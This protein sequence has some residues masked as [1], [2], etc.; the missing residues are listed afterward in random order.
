MD[1]TKW[2][3]IGCGDVTE[4]KS[5]PAFKKVS[6]SSLV[7]VMRRDAVKAKD[8]ALRHG[9]PAW[10]DDASMLIQDPEV[11]AVYIAT[12]PVYHEAYSIAALEAGKPVYLEK[13][14]AMNVDSCQRILDASR[15]HH[16]KLCI[17]HYRRALPL[18]IKVGEL[19]RKNT[20]GTI[21]LVNLQL[22]QAPKSFP[23]SAKEA[24]WRVDPSISGGG[25]FHDLAPHQLDLI[26]NWFGAVEK[27]SGFSANQG[28]FYLSDDIVSGEFVFANGTF[29]KGL[30]CFT[31]ASSAAKDYCEIIGSEERSA[32]PF[33]AT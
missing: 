18:F 30:W 33:S 24:N 28:G 26:M 11:N 17:A 2:G 10:Y 20:I 27:S 7:A 5:G 31:V 22:L 1:S 8:Y 16:T 21:R 25:L 29:F 9:V 15:L 14:M 12:P 4:V 3:I 32:F 6:G 23:E 13:P 19:I